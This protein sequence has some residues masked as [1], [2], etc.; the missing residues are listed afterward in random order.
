MKKIL[1]CIN[2]RAGVGKSKSK[3]FD[4]VAS[5]NDLDCEVSV[6]VI[7]PE[8]R[9]VE[10]ILRNHPS[11]FDVYA[12]CGGDGTLNHF[13]NA[14]KS[15]GMEQPIGYYPLGSTNDFARTIWKHPDIRS[16]SRSIAEGECFCYDIGSFNARYFNYVAAFGAFTDVSYSTEQG[17][18]NA[19][20]HMAYVVNGIASLPQSLSQNIALHYRTETT[21]HSGNYI[22]GSVSNTTSIGGFSLP[23]THSAELNDGLFEVLLVKAPANVYELGEIVAALSLGTINADNPYIEVFQTDHICFDFEEPVSWT[24]DGEA[25]G[26][27]EHTEIQVEKKAMK[28][29]V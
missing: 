16:I 21:E 4:I 25:G 24:L 8:H 29:M 22:F 10:E 15:L 17:F 18:K 19:L 13:I 2:P 14:Y 28:L 5:L 12:C 20:G 27:A 1:L 7:S 26:A 11:G 23:F 3:L 6:S 9:P